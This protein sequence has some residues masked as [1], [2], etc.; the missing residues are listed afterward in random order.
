[1]TAQLALF[2]TPSVY[3]GRTYNDKLDG[4]RLDRQLDRVRDLMSDGRWR[5]LAQIARQARGT[6]AAVSARLRDL[7]KARF[8]GFAVTGKRCE[9]DGLWVYRVEPK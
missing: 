3:D 9:V 5:T 4:A 1:M 8:G 6:E 7:R 2:V